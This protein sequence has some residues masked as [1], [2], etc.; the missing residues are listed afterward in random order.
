MA[1]LAQFSLN[2]GE[3]DGVRLLPESAFDTM[4]AATTPT[5]FADFPFVIHPSMLMLEWGNGWFLGDIA[6]P[7]AEYRRR[8]TRLPARCSSCPMRTWAS[9]VG[10]RLATDEYYARHCRRYL[11]DVAGEVDRV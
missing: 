9:A 2:R 1:K 7:A 4:W 3:L 8:R 10:N 11:G 5:P 6:L